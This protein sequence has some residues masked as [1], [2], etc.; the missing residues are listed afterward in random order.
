MASK[1]ALFYISKIASNFD[2][3]YE[4]SVEIAKKKSSALRS[5]FG[6]KVFK[7]HAWVKKCH[8]GDFSKT[9][10]RHFLTCACNLIFRGAKCLHLKCCESVI[11]WFY[12]S[13]AVQV[14]IHVNK[15]GWDNLKK[16]SVEL[17]NEKWK[18]YEFLDGLERWITYKQALFWP[19][20]NLCVD[21]TIINLWKFL[22]KEMTAMPRL[23]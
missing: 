18:I 23:M 21:P 12:V 8:F 15:N 17:K 16:P 4:C 20:K 7:L 14:L 3:S 2:G 19:F 1:M 11:I 6:S 5:V 22:K 9:A 10:K 13:G